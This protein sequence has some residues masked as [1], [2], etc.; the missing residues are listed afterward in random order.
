[1][2]RGLLKSGMGL[3]GEIGRHTQGASGDALAFAALEAR[4]HVGLKQC[5]LPSAVGCR[6]AHGHSGR[7]AGFE[8]DRA[9]ELSFTLGSA[10][11]RKLT[12][13]RYSPGLLER[14]TQRLH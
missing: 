11:K 4:Q 10:M 8:G 6:V 13:D 14:P 9:A 7:T 5:C 1:M 3:A 12:H 2:G